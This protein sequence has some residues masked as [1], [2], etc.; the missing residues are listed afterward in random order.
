M[1]RA[2]ITNLCTF[3]T[4]VKT[5]L[6]LHGPF[7]LLNTIRSRKPIGYCIFHFDEEEKTKIV[8][9]KFMDTVLNLKV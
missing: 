4:I 5:R 7:A 6:I 2:T 3:S 1:S 9:E 8:K